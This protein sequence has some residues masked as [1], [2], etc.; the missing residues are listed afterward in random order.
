MKTKCPYGELGLV[1]FSLF[2]CAA[3]A[4]TAPP[5]VAVGLTTPGNGVIL[6]GTT[7]NPNTGRGYRHHWFSNG[8][9]VC[10]LDP[11]V[12]TGGTTGPYAANSFTCIT[13]PATKPG[14]LTFDARTNTLYVVDLGSKSQ[15]I[16]RL[17]FLPASDNGHGL[18]DNVHQ[19]VVA[20]TC[21][22]A[23]NLPTAAA[24]GPDGNLYVGFKKNGNIIR[25][26]SPQTE[27]V[28]CSNVNP[29][30]TTSDAKR[31]AGLAWVLSDLYGADGAGPFF[32]ASATDCAAGCKGIALNVGA[33]NAPTTVIASP[34]TVYFGS[35][36][37]VAAYQV[38]PVPAFN[39]NLASGFQFLSGLTWDSNLGV[40]WVGDDLTNGVSAGTG[41]WFEPLSTVAQISAPGAPAGVTATA[42]DSS[43]VVSWVRS[44][45][46]Q[47]ITSFTVRATN[48]ADG[49]FADTMNIPGTAT[50]ATITGLTN[51]VQYQ[52]TVQA[53]NSAGTSPFSSPSNIVTP[54]KPAPP[55]APT[56]VS[57]VPG[58][59]S[60][61]VTWTASVTHAT[62]VTG[63]VVSAYAK[64]VL[65]KT[66]SV[67]NVTN[68]LVTG[69]TNGTD[70]NFTVQAQ[71]LQ[72]ASA[73][74]A[75]SPA[76]QP[77]AVNVDLQVT[78][79]GPA[80][81][82]IGTT[83]TYVTTVINN[84]PGTASQAIVSLSFPGAPVVGTITTSAGTCTTPGTGTASCNL[85][86]MLP[87]ATATITVSVT[88][89]GATTTTATVQGLDPAGAV[90]PDTNPVNNTF[91]LSTPVAAPLATTDL[92]VTGS[93]K[94][95]GPAVGTTDTYTWQI[96]NGKTAATG[97]V[98]T[99]D[100]PTNLAFQRATSNLGTCTGPALNTAGGTVTC[101]V[102]TVGSTA[103]IVTIDYS[104]KLPGTIVSTGHVSF[105][106]TDTNPANDTFKVTVT[107]K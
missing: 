38:L 107:A 5:P 63:Y 47:P 91:S 87:N 89:N 34:T 70:Y 16:V 13:G 9:Q 100:F 74:S 92:Q 32:L 12:D 68:A 35:T 26:N 80:A 95:G 31:T 99:A 60:A 25:I 93:A 101:T 73:E 40:L 97:V 94:V 77:S 46:G 58:N 75:P 23:G 24:V 42:G 88:L 67:G 37:N 59:A 8:T 49:T 27:P 33:I 4:Q 6:T 76:V 29:I 62:P 103:L 81:V 79:T 7:L 21:G 83:A 3:A 78:M 55:E 19:E 104:V 64:S 36:L 65:I 10:R 69:L 57:A 14:P 18:L 53:I 86:Q 54:E 15:G 48:V 106:G 2:S 1:L 71:S 50:S 96:R 98:F 72:G 41:E 105:N 102:D 43:A 22:L 30:G 28:P 52:F 82:P 56:G 17:H 20:A 84:G 90:L 44:G 85:G 39:P 51:L 66:V 61:G 45:D 11:D